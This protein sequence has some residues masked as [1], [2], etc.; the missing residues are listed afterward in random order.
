M[1]NNKP[2]FDIF[3]F[4]YEITEGLPKI[5][6]LGNTKVC[7]ENFTALEE[8]KNNTVKLKCKLNVI[9]ILGENLVIK[10]IREECIE[11]CGKI[12]SLRFI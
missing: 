7:V 11:I 2:V 4:G 8:Y 12:T 5:T 10:N 9:D 6:F 3:D 1:K